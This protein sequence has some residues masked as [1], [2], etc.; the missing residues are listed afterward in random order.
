MRF[1]IR[2]LLY[3]PQRLHELLEMR[4]LESSRANFCI[5]ARVILYEIFDP[6]DPDASF[7]FAALANCRFSSFYNVPTDIISFRTLHCLLETCWGSLYHLMKSRMPIRLSCF[8]AKFRA[9]T[10]C[11]F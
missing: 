11:R 8:S 4:L 9:V 1:S 3:L 5:Y 2:K 6:L 7:C 10:G